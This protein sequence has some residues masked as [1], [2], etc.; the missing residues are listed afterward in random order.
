M[1]GG[2][3]VQPEEV[4][5]A[6][7]AFASQQETPARLGDGL[8]G[9]READA[10][11]PMLNGEIQGLLG[12]FVTALTGLTAGLTRNAAGLAQNAQRYQAAETAVSRGMDRIRP[13]L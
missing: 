12:Q 13:Q 2:F 9:A 8:N 7:Q 6:S 4:T 10:G 11:D 3:M 1:S 5:G